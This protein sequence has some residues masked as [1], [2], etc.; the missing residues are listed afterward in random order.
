MAIDTYLDLP[1]MNAA[2]KEY[3]SDQVVE[4][5]VYKKNAALALIDKGEDFLGKNKPIPLIIGVGQ[6]RSAVFATA[7]ANQTSE[8]IQ[9]FALT[10]KSDYAVGT[11]DRQT[12]LASK[13]NTAAFLDATKVEFEGKIRALTNS[14]ASGMF[15]AGTGSIG[16]ISALP[17]S[18]VITLT[19]ASDVVNFEVGQTLQANA[20]DGGATPR[21]AVG[22]VVKV[23][24]NTGQIT[25]AATQGGNGAD[26]ASWAPNDFLLTQGDNNA[27]ISGFGA[28]VPSSDPA[29]TAFYGVDRSVDPV[30]LGGV[31]LD[32]SD[33]PIEEGL[34]DLST[35]IGREGGSPDMAFVNPVTYGYLVKALGAKVQY[36]DVKASAEIGFKA[37]EV[38]G[39]DGV[40]KVVGDRNCPVAVTF[41]LQMDTWKLESAGKA[42]HMVSDDGL[43]FLRVSNADAYEVR[44]AYYANLRTNA[45]GWNGFATLSA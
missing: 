10:R 3:Y 36:V 19:N 16:K 17:G 37:I 28:W 9:A 21:A 45:P 1:A 18:G 24:R 39:P 40:I 41:M 6:G 23:N 7:Q 4:N 2:L 22:I 29:A 34:I 31:R 20:T 44:F 15:R 12:M 5:L 11:I 8:N 27:K 25:V 26:P 38:H 30:R 35:I 33:R 43:Q 32:A 42:P 14:L 13:G